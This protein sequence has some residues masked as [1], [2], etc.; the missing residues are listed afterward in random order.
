MLSVA[1]LALLWAAG[2]TAHSGH[3]EQSSVSGPFQSLWYTNLPGD[4][5]TQVYHG[6]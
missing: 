6:S 2:V 5:G 1:S 4:G 3:A